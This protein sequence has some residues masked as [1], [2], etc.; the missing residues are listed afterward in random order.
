MLYLLFGFVLQTDNCELIC[1][2]GVAVL[3][4]LLFHLKSSE[5]S[6]QF[7][8]VSVTPILTEIIAKLKDAVSIAKIKYQVLLND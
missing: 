6:H 5:F 8:T 2:H 1:H 3:E 7:S 4:K